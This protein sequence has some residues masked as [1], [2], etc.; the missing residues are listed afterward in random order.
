MPSAGWAHSRTIRSGV[1][2]ATSSMSMPPAWEAM[3]T[4]VARAR[5]SVIERYSS[6]STAEA[7]STSTERTRMPSGGVWGVLSFM[8]R[9][10]RAARSAPSASSAS[11]MPP[12]LPRPPACTCAL[13]TTRLPS[14][15]ATARASAG[16]VA[17]SPVG[18]GTPNSRSRALAWYSW[19]FTDARSGLLAPELPQEPQDGV[20][21]VGRPLLERDDPVV[22]DLDVLGTDLGAA[23]GDVAEP[24]PRVLLD[25]GRAVAGVQRMHVEARDLDEEARSGED[26]LL[27]LVVADHV[28]D[29]LA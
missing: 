12:A 26:A 25:E 29:V 10:W 20:E 7:S 22:G 16:V 18:T 4:W 27:V 1:R 19:I 21:R 8:P 14:R 28:A 17:T 6:R 5:S 3:T 23:L 15:V 24:D 13:T 2:A 9:I 11:L